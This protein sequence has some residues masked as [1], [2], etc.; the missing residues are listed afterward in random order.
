MSERNRAVL[1]VEQNLDFVRDITQKFA[2]LET[3]RIIANG[4][5]DELTPDVVQR[6]LAV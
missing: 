5:I 2:I 4:G 1:L 3:G 6:H